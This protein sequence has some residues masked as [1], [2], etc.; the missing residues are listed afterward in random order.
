MS[1]TANAY[2]SALLRLTYRAFCR[3]TL[4]IVYVAIEL[5][6]YASD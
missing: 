3:R 6:I 1:D 5:V 2:V 4:Y